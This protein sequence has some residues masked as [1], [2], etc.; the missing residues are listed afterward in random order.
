MFQHYFYATVSDNKDPDGLNRVRV[1]MLGKPE[2]VSDWIPV[3]MPFA[4]PGEGV[5][6]IPGVGDAV[7]VVSLD[8]KLRTKA[9]IGAGWSSAL[10][11]PQTGENPAAELNED[12]KNSLKFIRSRAGTMLIFDD[13]EGEEKFQLISADGKTRFEYSPADDEASLTSENDITISAKGKII[14][15]A[16]EI[17]ISGEKQVTISAEEVQISAAKDCEIAADKDVSVKGSGISL[18]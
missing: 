6:M 7:M 15:E 18:N 2:S 11:P 1:T 13:T 16:E 9:V 3:V 5:S 4:G 10:K 17:E 8:S 14:I 12:G